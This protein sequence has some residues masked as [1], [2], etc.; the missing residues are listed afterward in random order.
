MK[1]VDL[2]NGFAAQAAYHGAASM[3]ILFVG[4]VMLGRL[5]NETLKSMPPTYP[6]GN[7]L[8]LFRASDL[9][10]GNLECV[11][12]DLGTVGPN[13]EDLSFQDRREK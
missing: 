10:I 5:V 7:T 2:V 8:P 12:S 9:R 4:D 1:V 3:R 6:W 13:S 11:L